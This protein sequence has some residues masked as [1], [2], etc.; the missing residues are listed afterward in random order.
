M[1]CEARLKEWAKGSL[2][3]LATLR[4]EPPWDDLAPLA[5]MI[6]DA[7][8]VGLGEG[9]H[10]AAEPLEF[11]NRLFRFLVEEKGFTAIAIESGLVES[12]IVH[13]YV[14]G[15]PGDLSMIMRHGF[16]WTFDLLP[17][18]R[19]L[20]A[21]LRARNA[22]PHCVRKINFYGFDVPG[23]IGPPHATHGVNA[24]LVSA[25]E[26]LTDVDA[27]SAENFHGRLGQDADQSVYPR[28]S[29]VERDALT[30]CIADLVALL[31]R[32][33]A[34]YLAVSSEHDYEWGY[35]AAICARQLDDQL[36]RIPLAWQPSGPPF[37]SEQTLFLL[38]MSDM[39]DRDQ[40]DNLRWI[41]EREGPSG[42]ILIFAHR[43]HL[44]ATPVTRSFF[45]G[46]RR[47][48]HH[49]EMAGS[50]LK[51][52]FGKRLITI[53][54]LIGRGQAACGDYRENID[55]APP[56][57]IDGFVS[58][59]EVPCFVLDL[60]SAP[61]ALSHCLDQ[62][63]SRAH[64]QGRYSFSLALGRAFDLLLHFGSVSP[65]CGRDDGRAT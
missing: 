57:S 23:S 61:V 25:L 2:A 48:E 33:K 39:R 47:V 28:M 1:T 16:S 35:R 17:Q 56:D 14:R 60:R 37:P 52:F 50:Y 8:L 11:R 36:R 54:N 18:N 64:A 10:C 65:A 46:S 19:A 7:S 26:Y 59:V 34:R 44:S 51:R 45:V 58:G 15:G 24:A 32:E 42:K 55:P 20:V 5:R 29:A 4:A 40:A 6:D 13:E 63:R 21:W 62:E 43:Y 9:V 12:R 3:P 38:D 31:E 53:G 41:A 30:V 49:H 22:D 27:A